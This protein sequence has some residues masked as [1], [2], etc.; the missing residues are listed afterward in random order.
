MSV[1]RLH[2]AQIT[3]PRGAEE[4]A[5]RFYCGLLGLPE[6]PK[7]DALAGRGGFWLQLGDVQLHV[8][9]EDGVDRLATKAHI[10]YEVDDIG[11]WRVRLADGGVEVIEAIELPGLARFE[12]RDPF[13]NRIEF[14]QR[15]DDG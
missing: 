8:G 7:P 3:V 11:A 9:A 4:E 14:L 13:G 15:L 5:R 12:A 2:H 1:R 10:G 6:V